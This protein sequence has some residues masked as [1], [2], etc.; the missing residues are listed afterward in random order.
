MRKTLALAAFAALATLATT[1]P[2][3]APAVAEEDP[4]TLIDLPPDVRVAFLEHMRTH[5]TS[6]D[7]VVQHVAAGQ[8]GEAGTVARREMAIGQGLGFGRYMPP[9][10]REMGFEYH[11]T[12]D[13]FAKIAAAMPAEPTSADWKKLVAGL[14][15]ITMR[16]NGCHGAFRVR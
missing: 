8:F 9:E 7:T 2:V 4:R 11:R 6:L 13:D 15:E 10:F 16:C 1:L 12:A 5:M 3:A 14:S